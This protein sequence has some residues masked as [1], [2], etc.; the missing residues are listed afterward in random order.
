MFYY[1]KCLIETCELKK[2]TS[3][4]VTSNRYIYFFGNISLISHY[5]LRILR[6]NFLKMPE[7]FLVS[8]R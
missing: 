3:L 2:L 4:F 7:F 6:I 1:K 5:L 8:V